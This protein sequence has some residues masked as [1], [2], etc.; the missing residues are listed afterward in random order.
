MKK[1]LVVLVILTVVIT[2]VFAD[3]VKTDSLLVYGTIGLGDILFKTTQTSTSKIDLIGEEDMQ[4]GGDGVEVGY[5]EFAATSQ[6]VG[7]V[8]KIEY[9]YST[10]SSDDTGEEFGFEA[11]EAAISGEDFYDLSTKTIAFDGSAAVKTAV[12]V[13]LTEV[14]PAE[15]PPAVDYK[16][17]ITVNLTTVN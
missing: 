3:V 4:M 15:T 10:L 1:F 14:I 13:R 5:W 17:T 8:F 7:S 11:V 12:K 6:P 2:G 9:N 16:G